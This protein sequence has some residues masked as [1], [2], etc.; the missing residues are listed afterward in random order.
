M[1]L[2]FS[3]KSYNFL[4]R[5]MR[6][7]LTQPKSHKITFRWGRK[8]RVDEHGVKSDVSYNK[9]SFANL[10]SEKVSCFSV[11]NH[12][13]KY[14]EDEN[15]SIATFLKRFRFPEFDLIESKFYCQTLN[16]YRSSKSI[17]KKKI[18]CKLTSSQVCKLCSFSSFL[19]FIRKLSMSLN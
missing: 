16:F 18:Y 10:D 19:T 9:D 8:E 6:A 12:H 15:N 3:A 17:Q 11:N 7:R 4:R 1:W 2:G 5:K 14:P 13:S